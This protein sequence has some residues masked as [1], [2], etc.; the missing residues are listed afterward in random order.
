MIQQFA[1]KHKLKISRDECG[2]PII[3]GKRG[4]LYF[5]GRD[6]CTMW[7]DA[8]PIM[9]SRLE[10]L[11]GRVWQGDISRGPSGRRVQD[12][13]VRGIRPEGYKLV[14]RLVGAK[15]RRVMSEAQ[16]EA[17]DKARRASSLFPIRTVQDGTLRA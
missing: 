4:H 10:Q 3:R 13:S 6:V 14:I 2:D 8:P 5:D 9:R 16:R 1:E 7:T 17:L 15:P 11:G 12:A